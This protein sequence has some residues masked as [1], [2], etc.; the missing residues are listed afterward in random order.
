MRAIGVRLDQRRPG[1]DERVV[2][3]VSR[4]EVP[5][6]EDV[7]ELRHELSE[8]RMETVNMFCSLNLRQLA[9]GPRQFQVDF[10]VE[11]LLGPSR[12]RDESMDVGGCTRGLRAYGI[13][14]P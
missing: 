14:G 6:E 3:A 2:D 5:A 11:R 9:L 1:A 13:V 8:V 7:N 10:G 4:C 12:H